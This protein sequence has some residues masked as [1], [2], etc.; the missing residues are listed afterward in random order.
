MNFSIVMKR[1]FLAGVLFVC[2]LVSSCDK[3]SPI[4][5]TDIRVLFNPLK[6]YEIDPEK[7][8]W[9]VTGSHLKEGK[10]FYSLQMTGLAAYPELATLEGSVKDYEGRDIGN[11]TT[12]QKAYSH[13]VYP[14][15]RDVKKAWVVEHNADIPA[16]FYY[17]YIKGAPTITADQTLWGLPAGS[18]LGES[19]YLKQSGLIRQGEGFFVKKA[20][21]AGIP[22]R[23]FF[24]QN[25]LIPKEFNLCS[26]DPLSDAAGGTSIEITISLPVQ[27]EYFWTYAMQL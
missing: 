10:R 16:Y 26:E 19:F 14:R 20:P 23:E 17:M 21:D 22:F 8:S 18:D 4:Y 3:L 13:T 27:I 6:I 2:G 24:C 12:A 15:V 7:A 1:I 9:K 11:A 5:G 25:A